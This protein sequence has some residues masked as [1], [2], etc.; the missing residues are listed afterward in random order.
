MVALSIYSGSK[1]TSTYT[2]PSSLFQRT[3]L[4]GQTCGQMS[5]CKTAEDKNRAT[6]HAFSLATLCASGRARQAAGERAAQQFLR[7][8]PGGCRPAGPG[9][10]WGASTRR[11][12]YSCTLEGCEVL[13]EHRADSRLAERGGPDAVTHPWAWGTDTPRR[14]PPGRPSPGAGAAAAAE[15]DSSAPAGSGR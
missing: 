9:A 4:A 15:D 6:S 3:Y 7:A 2:C 5:P 11:Y 12:G 13:Y 8:I 1:Q 10:G 14:L